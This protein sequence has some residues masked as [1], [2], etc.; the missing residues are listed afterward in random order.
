MSYDNDG[1]LIL[2]LPDGEL[3]EDMGLPKEAHLA[4]VKANIKRIIDANTKEC[5]VTVQK[6]GDRQ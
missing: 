6:W 2:L 3:K 1:M 4:S 5:L